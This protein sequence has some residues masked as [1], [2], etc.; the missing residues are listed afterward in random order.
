MPASGRRPTR[1]RLRTREV[2]DGALAAP[3][4]G[5][6]DD[7]HPRRDGV[8]LHTCLTRDH[9]PQAERQRLPRRA[10]RPRRH[11]RQPAVEHH[12]G[13]GAQLER[14]LERDVPGDPPVVE[15]A[16]VA[17]HRRIDGRD[18]RARPQGGEQRAGGQHD[19]LPRRRV[20][21]DGGEADGQVLDAQR[22]GVPAEGG[23]QPRRRVER[24]GVA[25][26]REHPPPRVAGE[27][28][29]AVEPVPDPSE[30]LPRAARV[31][32]HERTVDCPR[33]R[34][35]HQIGGDARLGHG[36]QHA[37]L[38]GAERTSPGQHERDRGRE[39]DGHGG[40]PQTEKPK[41]AAAVPPT[42][43]RTSSSATPAN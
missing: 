32:G 25:P 16:P 43:A 27:Q 15:Q 9:D 5:E 38:D 17:L 23:V 6:V 29:V 34:A 37:H 2:E 28:L 42:M 1:E 19:R 8:E 21:G 7:G 33:R 13:P 41:T 11:R 30:A 40:A 10:R 31:H 12:H 20:H 39:R 26:H 3:R 4:P 22:P 18:R 36:L 24:E 35:D 14:P